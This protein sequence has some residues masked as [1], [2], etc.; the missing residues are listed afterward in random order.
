MYID[1]QGPRQLIGTKYNK[2]QL[3]VAMI[4]AASLWPLYAFAR[5][6]AIVWSYCRR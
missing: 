5:F 3:I 1:K 6:L 2:I 4:L